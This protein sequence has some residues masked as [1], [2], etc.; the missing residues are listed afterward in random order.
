MGFAW[1]P[2]IVNSG[3]NALAMW[4]MDGETVG[5]GIRRV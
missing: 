4:A 2:W 1:M 5:L 3:K